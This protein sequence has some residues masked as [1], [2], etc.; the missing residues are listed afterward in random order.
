MC[1]RERP[2]PLN[3]PS[4]QMR[5]HASGPEQLLALWAPESPH[6]W[7]PSRAPAQRALAQGG[8]ALDLS[9]AIRS[10][11][12]TFKNGYIEALGGRSLSPDLIHFDLNVLVPPAP[13]PPVPCHATT[14]R[15][16]YLKQAWR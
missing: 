8:M 7:E 1:Q 2:Y 14:Q 16:D 10:L 9:G 6:V 3:L 5:G 12:I 13:P 15:S 4:I 11:K